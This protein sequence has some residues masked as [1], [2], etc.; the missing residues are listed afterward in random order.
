MSI[1][2]ETDLKVQ[3]QLNLWQVVCGI[4]YHGLKTVDNWTGDSFTVTLNGQDFEYKTGIGHRFVGKGVDSYSA[5]LI[6]ANH[7]HVKAWDNSLLDMQKLFTHRSFETSVRGLFVPVPAMAGVIWSVL[8]DSSAC[9]TAFDGW[10]LD[11]GY[12]TDSRKALEIYLACQN[13][14]RKLRNALNSNQINELRTIL[15][16]Y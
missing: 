11:L 12:D 5:N 16:D 1:Y 3:T 4:K 2:S 10:C 8:M 13:S 15:E 6:K 14:Y 7:K 9:E